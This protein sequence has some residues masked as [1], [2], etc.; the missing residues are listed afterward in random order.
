MRVVLQCGFYRPVGLPE[1]R[2]ERRVGELHP[3]Q[4]L[5]MLTIALFLP[6]KEKKNVYG[7]CLLGSRCEK[8][9]RVT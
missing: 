4:H 2:A 1:C 3:L 6:E 8:T 5:D 7:F 9:T